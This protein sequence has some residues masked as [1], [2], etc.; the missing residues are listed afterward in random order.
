MSR[1]LG[2]LYPDHSRPPSL[3]NPLWVGAM[4]TGD[5][6]DNRWEKSGEFCVEVCS[7]TRTAGI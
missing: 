7:V 2:L 4:S 5:G 6:F 3:A 1:K